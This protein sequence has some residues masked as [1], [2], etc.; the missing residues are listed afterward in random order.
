[1]TTRGS[2]VTDTMSAL[3]LASLLAVAAPLPAAAQE[4]HAFNVAAP[5]PA[6]A[7]RAFGVQAGIQILASADDLRGKK[8]N[9]VSGKI[10]TEQAL[11]DLLA[12]TGLDH[13]YV[14]DRAVALVADSTAIGAEQNQAPQAAKDKPTADAVDTKNARSDKVRLA[15]VDQ[16]PASNPPE[17]S[18]QPSEKKP[19]W[20]E[21]V[22]VT[23][24]RIPAH[25]KEGAQEVKIYTREKIEQSGQT[26]VSDFLNTLPEAAIARTEYGFQTLYGGATVQLHGLPVGTTLVLINGRRIESSGVQA[27]AGYNFF[28]LN[29]IPVAAVERIEVMSEGSSAIY[30]SDAIAGVVNII[31]RKGFDGLEAA[32][33]YGEASGINESHASLS[34]G[35][36]WDKGSLSIVGS[37]QTRGELAGTERSITASNDFRPFGGADARSLE[38]SPSNVFFPGGYSFNG[39]PPVKYA[40][41]PV[42][43]T[44]TPSIQEFA[45]TAGTLNKCSLNSYIPNIPATH[46]SGVFA[47]GNYDPMPSVEL[48]TELMFSHVKEQPKNIPAG[49]F[50]IVTPF[51]T[52]APYTVSA[53]NPYNPFGRTVGVSDLFTSLGPSRQPLTTDFFRSLAGARGDFL[54]GWRWEVAGWAAQDTS[55]FIETNI[56]DNAAIRNALNSADPA[57]A[58]NPFTA[59]T[60]ASPQ[61]MQSLVQELVEKFRGRT[62]AANGFVHGPIARLPAGSVELLVG[63]EYNRDTLY[64]DQISGPFSLPNTQTTY[65]RHSYAVFSEA[66]VPILAR[67]A[68]PQ[69]GDTLAVTLAGRY[70]S[71][72]DFGHKTTPQFG[73]QWRPFDTLLIRGSYGRAFK[74]PSLFSLHSPMQSFLSVVPDPLNGNQNE[75][76]QAIT[77]GNPRL[78]PETGQSRTFGIVYASQAIPGLRLSLTHWSLDE[79]N[80]IQSLQASTIVQN[81]SLFPG[82][83]VRDATGVITQVDATNI[84]FGLIKVAGVDYQINYKRATKFGE[85][86]PSLS[87]TETY[88]YTQALTPGAPIVD[89]TSKAQDNGN[90]APRWKGTVA[91]GW[92]LGPYTANVAGRYIGEYQDYDSTTKIGNFWF[93]DANFRYAIGNVLADNNQWMKGSYIEI[94]GVN[95][96]NKLPEYSNFVFGLIGYDPAEA[97][98]RGRFLYMQAG[99]RW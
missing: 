28:D 59:G 98:I 71:Y 10:S 68:N 4:V 86:R 47:F 17:K 78:Q 34:W 5:D 94:G 31:L 22:V 56:P 65:H 48:F 38:C 11:N 45:S 20:T 76:V 72:S 36:H 96:F 23:G 95:L 74:A 69:L 35:K 18:E 57:T 49:L 53:S 62:L 3:L 7:I 61:V 15:Q 12:G 42:G 8:L 58:L 64:N 21:E 2:R 89:A 77:G 16:G 99:V 67:Q 54:D 85:W 24:S 87:A 60:Q 19:V 83:V 93:C 46:R 73:A 25:A 88:R 63:S 39:Q 79:S 70:D 91:V 81:E 26:T 13:R 14:G 29:N 37:Y 27:S 51:F 32:V 9:P 97:D 41:V 75:V 43:Y 82:R 55:D 40:A 30:G 52:Y 84:N 90:F 44:G 50:A 92:E 66:R 1:M 80:S 33:K 6:S